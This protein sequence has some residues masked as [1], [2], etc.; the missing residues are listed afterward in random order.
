MSS[1]RC[2]VADTIPFS[3][4]DGPGNRFVVFLQGCNFDCLAC[5]NPSTI[6]RRPAAGVGATVL[7]VDSIVERVRPAA[8]FLSGVTVT[9]GEPTLQSRFVRDLFAT[10]A[11]DDDLHRL[12]RLIDS[13]GATSPS[14]WRALAPVTDGV[15]LDLKCFDAAIHRRLTGRSNA[16]VLASIEQLA[17]LGLLCEVRLLLIPGI[18][19]DPRLLGRTAEWLAAIDPAM[20]IVLI[21]FRSDHVR[22]N[23][24]EVLRGEGWSDAAPGS[25]VAT[26]P[27]AIL[28]S[29]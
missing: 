21:P 10:L 20:R 11:S 3:C 24:L 16:P 17:G 18:N 5:H 25:R 7:D 28:A 8:P 27:S 13:N 19:D 26:T 14:T 29:T 4:V 15:M 2:L 9:G 1:T 12:T 22:R 6:A 23:A